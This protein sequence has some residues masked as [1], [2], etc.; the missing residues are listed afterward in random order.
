MI[1]SAGQLPLDDGATHFEKATPEIDVGPL[2][3]NQFPLA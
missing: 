3:S 2:Q 1:L